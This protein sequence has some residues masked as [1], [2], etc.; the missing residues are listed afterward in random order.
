MLAFSFGALV[1]SFITLDFSVKLVATHANSLM[2]D[3]FKFTSTWGNHEGSML[4]WVL[5]L[6]IYGALVAGFGRDLPLPLKARAL[7]VQA[8]ISV[9]FIAFI[10]FTSNPFERL[11][12]VP[13]DGRDLNPLLQDIGLAIHPPFLYLGYVRLPMVNEIHA[14]S[15]QGRTQRAQMAS[16]RPSRRAAMANE[17]AMEKPT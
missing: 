4:L 14:N 6:A 11:D 3:L 2:P 5:I 16:T 13:F 15:V 17:K 7:A 9:A 10:L 12:P 8:M 1:Y